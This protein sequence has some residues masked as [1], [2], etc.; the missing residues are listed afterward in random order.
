MLAAAS[1][2]LKPGQSKIWEI[3]YYVGAKDNALLHRY[4]KGL[5]RAINLGYFS[6]LG[7]LILRILNRMHSLTNN[8]GWAII[9]MTMLIQA[10][11]FPLTYKS[12]KAQA[13]MRRLQPEI[14]RLQQRY[15]K[16]AQKLN[17]EMMELY[18]KNG[19]NPIGGCLPMVLQMPVFISLYNSLRSSWELH[20]APWM[21]WIKDL[22]ARDPYYIL[23][24]VMGGLMYG[25]NKLNAQA[26]GDPTQQQM[27]TWMPVIFTFMFLKFPAGLVLYWL[28]N[29]L[30][31]ALV[32]IALKNHFAKTTA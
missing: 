3:P 14:T 13:A 9:L 18:K 30:A 20:A 4:G 22:S 31:N 24:V 25:Q 7:R 19:A 17:V 28:T 6:Q 10:A 1:V 23:P 2:S 26:G 12:L 15:A 27:M 29:S 32:Q 21:F 8:W 16:D 11:L 5:D